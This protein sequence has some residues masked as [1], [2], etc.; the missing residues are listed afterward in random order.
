VILARKVELP[1]NDTLCVETCRSDQMKKVFH[2]ALVAAERC[3]VVLGNK[4]SSN[5]ITEEMEEGSRKVWRGSIHG[6]AVAVSVHMTG[7]CS[8]SERI[9]K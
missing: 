4:N 7:C 6:P 8:L 5:R 1:D 3:H 2:L 9:P